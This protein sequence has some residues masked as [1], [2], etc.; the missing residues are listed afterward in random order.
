M[1]KRRFQ[2]V[3]SNIVKI[4][5]GEELIAG[6]LFFYFFCITSPF[7]I[8]KSLRDASYLNELGSENLPIAYAT[9]ILAGFVVAFHSKLQIK[10]SRQLLIIGSL[11]IFIITCL[12]FTIFFPMG[13]K[14]LPL[15][16]WVWANL[17]VVV[18]VT[19]FW[20]TVNDVFN[21]REAKRLIGFFGSG[22]ILG[23]IV[24]G[25]L[26][27]VLAKSNESYNLLYI[28]SGFFVVCIIIVNFIFLWKE[29][30]ASFEGTKK[31]EKA[32]IKGKVG[33]RDCFNAVRKE[34]YVKLIAILII[35][36]GIV[37]TF[38]D[39][40]SKNVIESWPSIKD[41]LTAFFGKFNA[42]L[43]IFSFIIQLL[44]TSNLIKRFGIR[45]T[46]LLYPLSL[47]LCSLGIAL[48]PVI[49]F[50]IAIKGI[51][52]SLSYSLNQSA[53]ELLY[54][55]IPYELK[56]KAKVFIDMFLNRFAKTIGA[57]I[58]MI[59]FILPFNFGIKFVSL[60]TSLFIF[61]WIVFNMKVSKE[62]TNTLKNRL[63]MKWQRADMIVAENIDVD[64]TKLVFDTIES[65]DQSSVL[66]AMNLF[67]LL[68]QDKLTPEMK[69]L[70]SYK[71]D[72]IKVSSLDV[73]FE[74]NSLMIPESEER[75]DKELRNEIKEVMSLDIYQE[76]MKFHIEK[77]LKEDTQEAEI[78]KMEIAKALGFMKPESPLMSKLEELLEDDSVDVVRYA[79][80]SAGK[81]KKREYVPLLVKK[82]EN[83][84]TREDAIASLKKYGSSILG[85]LSDYLGD[86][87][88]NNE[89]RR[90]VAS[91]LS[92]NPVQESADYLVWE[93]IRADDNIRYD[94]INALDRIYT[95]NPDIGFDENLITVELIRLVK[96]YCQYFI[97]Q[98]ALVHR[99]GQEKMD[100]LLNDKLN[101]YI[102]N[103]FILLELIY[104]HADIVK[105]LQNIQIGTKNSVAYAIELLDNILRKK[106]KDIVLPLIDDVKIEER[107]KKFRWILQSY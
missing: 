24:G 82:L 45:T 72:E 60:I 58:L 99:E 17:L 57:V 25:V 27:G 65:K 77:I 2:K 14:W 85:T 42:G 98:Y 88:E 51:D 79:I 41:N 28:A 47:L 33:F 12:L 103:I 63:D 21:P 95:E 73:L 34:K 97:A 106:I 80:D 67:D 89:V 61:L 8:I 104:P 105:A 30:N 70:V 53:R 75:V 15:A 96:K 13:W 56:Y 37:S 23:G 39:W 36:T 107:I 16:Y 102:K 26:T 94:I 22:G 18:L 81:I 50:A 20:I 83:P 44:L 29:K 90:T 71:S 66:Y 31:R 4:K 40:Q 6:L 59:V 87:E 35:I 100:E 7:T 101:I 32:S 84:I 93:L 5:P 78:K 86:H 10:I 11:I 68:E 69:Q 52:K 62:Y 48:W 46:L 49:Y 91:V 3:F 38:I 74:E 54:I 9:A 76:V 43:L 55:P 64:Y 1:A 19:Q 92:C